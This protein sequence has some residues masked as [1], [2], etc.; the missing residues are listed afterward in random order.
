MFDNR[1]HTF[2][3]CAYGESPFLEACIK[4]IVNQDVVT[5]II[6]T[7]STF[8]TH[9][10]KLADSYGIPLFFNENST[11]IASDWNF[12][13]EQA[14]TALVTIAHQDDIY[15]ENYTDQA[16]H[17][18]NETPNPLIFFSNYY[19]LRNDQ[20]VKE[21]RLLNTK[22]LLLRPLKSKARQNSVFWRRRIL[23]IGSVICCPSVTL[24][25]QV[26]PSQIFYSN[27][28]NNLDWDAWEKLSHA[29]GSFVYC[30]DILMYHRIHES[31]ATSEFIRDKTRSDE[32]LQMFMRF[33]P[34]PIAK[35]INAFY[36][37]SQ[38]SNSL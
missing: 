38:K 21:N 34:K 8:N 13:F 20:I 2:S 9:I 3:I 5:N 19:E 24:V 28:N 10:K 11:G 18:I 23:S 27:F 35:M 16:L 22:R 30:P 33:W 4:S 25:K 6:M 29:K 37:R 1:D 15:C 31:S 32:D 7:T 36:S 26:L 14:Q 17:H 12:S